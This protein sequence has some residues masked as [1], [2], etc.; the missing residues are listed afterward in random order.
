MSRILALSALLSASF[1]AAAVPRVKTSVDRG[2]EG[3]RVQPAR[4]VDG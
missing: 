3:L 1:A 4:V 2:A